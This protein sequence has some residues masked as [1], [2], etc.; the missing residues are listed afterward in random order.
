MSMKK[1]RNRLSAAKDDLL[2]ERQQKVKH[3]KVVLNYLT[4]INV[5]KF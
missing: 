2:L 4:I 1:R 5:N 3:Q